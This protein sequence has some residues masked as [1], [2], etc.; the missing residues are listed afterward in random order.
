MFRYGVTRD[1]FLDTFNVASVVGGSITI[2]H[3]RRAIDRVDQ[4][5]EGRADA[6]TDNPAN[7]QH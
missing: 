4:L 7:H 1:E 3:L 6:T 5:L 2:P